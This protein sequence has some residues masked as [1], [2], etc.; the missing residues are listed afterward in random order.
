MAIGCNHAQRISLSVLTVVMWLPLEDLPV[1]KSSH[2]EASYFNSDI[3]K[4]QESR[5]ERLSFAPTNILK[6]FNILQKHKLL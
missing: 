6:Y 2:K 5:W 3:F 4:R 1:L